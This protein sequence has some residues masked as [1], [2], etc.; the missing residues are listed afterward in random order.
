MQLINPTPLLRAAQAEGCAI[1][2]FNIH[3]L[4]TLEAVAEA[5]NEE[6]API[7]SARAAL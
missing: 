4:E 2:A 1:A 6:R 3:N 7:M 5:A